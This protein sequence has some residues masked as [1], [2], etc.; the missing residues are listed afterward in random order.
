MTKYAV[1]IIIAIFFAAAI[2]VLPRESFW[3]SDCGNKFIQTE[4]FLK[5]GK[6]NIDYPA[7]NVDPEMKYFP[8]CGHHFFK[9]D[10]KIYS[11]Y[12]AY[13]P[14][15]SAPL[16]KLA[17]YAGLYLLPALSA[18]AIALLTILTAR[19]CGI[20]KWLPLAGL[21]SIFATPAVFYGMVFWEETPAVAFSA[22]ALLL[23]IKAIRKS[24]KAPLFLIM[25]GILLAISTILREEG[26]IFFA[27][28][29]AAVLFQTRNLKYCIF[30]GLGFA[31]GILPLWLF[32]YSEW[33]HILGPHFQTYSEMEK[34]IP[35]SKTL[36]SKLT[37]FYV[38]LLRFTP[39]LRIPGAFYGMLLFPFLAAAVA[40]LIPNK[41]LRDKVPLS[42]IPL[43]AIASLINVIILQ[44]TTDIVFSTIFTQ[45]LLPF[46][47]FIVLSIVFAKRLWSLKN[48]ALRL[49]LLAVAAYCALTPLALNQ[50]DIGIIWGPR[51]FLFIIPAAIVLCLASLKFMPPTKIQKYSL[52]AII[53][54]SIML[55]Y[56]GFWTLY[57]KKDFSTKIT[58]KIESLQS[59]YVLSDV[60]WLPEDT[61]RLFFRKKFMQAGN[62][63][64]GTLGGALK[65]LRSNGVE[66]V[67]IVLSNQFRRISDKDLAGSMNSLTVNSW[68]ELKSPGLQFM[69]LT[70]FDCTITQ[71]PPRH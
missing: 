66:K 36:I 5:T 62:S 34:N 12:P 68:E 31:A 14:L 51:H 16:Y 46:M 35:L 67:T 39:D 54:S 44:K 28:L 25:S 60:F 17:G 63:A 43:A 11:F 15:I 33:G 58:A 27:A 61:A 41:K 42:I 64:D 26:Y 2:A 69:T 40:Q 70:V 50:R 47:P 55:E 22:L 30:M 7:G 53:F 48:P 23:A 45:S 32:Q 38:Y 20:K 57:A 37:N 49:L 13:F 1:L 18:I 6:I 3:I 65:L 21:A 4:N 9:K 56:N 29:A 59:E 10:D 8:Y 24:Q 19:F 52:L 71:P